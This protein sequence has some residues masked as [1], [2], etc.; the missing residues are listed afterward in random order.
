MSLS[1]ESQPES[2]PPTMK[3]PIRDKKVTQRQ[4]PRRDLRYR[5]LCLR[6]GQ[7]LT[8]VSF[9]QPIGTKTV[10]AAPPSPHNGRPEVSVKSPEQSEIMPPEPW[11]ASVES[12]ESPNESFSLSA[13]SRLE[14]LSLS[15]ESWPE[16]FPPMTKHPIQKGNFEHYN[17]WINLMT[18]V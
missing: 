12:T 3:P 2:F 10:T 16:S 15:T 17:S 4:T 9:C 1:A 8:L 7:P 6:W 13:E 5:K 14:S 11:S 18:E